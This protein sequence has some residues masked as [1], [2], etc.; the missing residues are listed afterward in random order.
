MSS[1]QR[2]CSSPALGMKVELNTSRN[3]GTVPPQ[4][5]RIRSIITRVSSVS[6]LPRLSRPRAQLP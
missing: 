4:P 6:S 1:Y 2:F 3:A 5:T